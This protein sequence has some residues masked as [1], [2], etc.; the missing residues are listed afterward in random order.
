MCTEI[1]EY[2]APDEIAVCNLA[3]IAI[4]KF[5]TVHKE[6]EQLANGETKIKKSGTFD[7][8]RLKE[9]TKIVTK[10]L[11]K[12]IDANFYPLKE[13]E[14]SNMRHRPIGIG[15]QVIIFLVFPMISIFLKACD[16]LCPEMMFCLLNFILLRIYYRSLSYLLHK[17]PC[18]I[19][20]GE[21]DIRSAVTI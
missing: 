8:D 16:D 3:S 7:F 14:N 19:C 6:T 13:A 11:N 4:N 17:V 20:K 10:N 15:I 12:V 21:H 2:T 9:V 5:V 18:N 1:I